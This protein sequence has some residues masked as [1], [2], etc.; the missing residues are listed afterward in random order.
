VVK[1]T[2][3]SEEGQIGFWFRIIC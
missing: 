2:R 1:T 3:P